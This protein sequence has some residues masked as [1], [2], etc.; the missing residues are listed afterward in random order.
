ML[1]NPDGESNMLLATWRGVYVWKGKKGIKEMD[2]SA[3][4]FWNCKNKLWNILVAQ[5]EMYRFKML[6]DINVSEAIYDFN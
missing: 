6:K 4:F 3:G 1:V 2:K 5:Y